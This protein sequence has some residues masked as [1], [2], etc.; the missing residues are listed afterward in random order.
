MVLVPTPLVFATC[1]IVRRSAMDLP[2]GVWSVGPTID[3]P[4]AGR[5]SEPEVTLARLELLLGDLPARVA[6]AQDRR[7]RSVQHPM[8]I[9]DLLDPLVG[10]LEHFGPERLD[11]T[12]TAIGSAVEQ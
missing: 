7:S 10:E 11:H 2:P 4:A 3:L 8:V 12:S 9:A 1:P 5:S 6:L